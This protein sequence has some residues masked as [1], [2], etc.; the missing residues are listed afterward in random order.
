VTRTILST[1][2]VLFITA[3]SAQI[4]QGG[5]PIGLSR[6]LPA[7]AGVRLPAVDLAALATEDQVNDLDKSIP[8]R[9]GKN[10][11][12]DLDLNNSGTWTTLEDG[13]RLWRLGIVCPGALSVNFEFHDFRPSAGGKVFVTDGWGQHIGAF[14]TANDHGEHVL[15]VQAM[16]GSSITIEYQ[17][18]PTGPVGHLRIGQVTHG[19]RDVFS[20][21]RALGSS[22]S[23]NNNVVC[24]VGDAWRDEIRSVAMIT[25]NGSGICTGTLINNCNSDGTPYFLTANHCLGSNVSTWVFR[26][27][28][29]SPSCTQNQ[30]G[31]TNQ[32]I[33]GSSLL[34]SNAGSD[35]G[36]LLLNSTP[37]AAYNVYYAGW[38]RSGATPTGQTAIHHPSGDV[39]KISFDTDDAG[40]ATYG[41]AACWRI[42]T[43]E[44]GTT[45][46][47]SSGS[48]LWDQNHRLIGQLY[49]GQ[50]TC[51][52]NVNDY[53]GR[54]DVSYPFIQ[55][56]LGS[57]GNTVDGF[58]PNAP[59][60]A[61]DAQLNSIS[62]VSGDPC[63]ASRS[64][65]ITI[66][67]GGTTTLSSFT[68]SWS[69]AGG[70]SGNI[71]WSGSLS[72]GATTVLS[73]GS[74]TLVDGANTFTASVTAPNGGV[75]QNTANDQAQRTSSF[76]TIAVTLDL[77]LDR[78]GEETSWEIRSGASVVASGGPFTREG[79]SGEY[80]Q[81]PIQICLASGCYDLV[82]LDTYGD[83]MCCQYG[84][85][86][87]DLSDDQANVLATGG[88]FTNT[89]THPFCVT[90]TAQVELGAKVF[91]EGPFDSGS[92][93]MGDALRSDGL[94]PTTE[95]YSA[96]GYT[97]V[98]GGGESVQSN[99]LSAT[100]SNAIVDW[101]LVELRG[102]GPSYS[103]AA[104]RCALLQRDGDV[105]DV[106][107]TSPVVFDIGPGNYHVAVRHRNHLGAMTAA[108]VALSGTSV[109]VDFRSTTTSLYGTEAMRTI[110]SARVLWA[111]NC[112]NDGFLRYT[113]SMNDRDRILTR[114]GGS[115]PTNTVAGYFLEDVNMDGQA[116]YTGGSNDRDPI[117]FNIGGSVP[118][119]SRTEQ[120]P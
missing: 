50:A 94:V 107:G 63:V 34:A 96:L 21:G 120:L 78:Y 111:G 97:Q 115:V 28:W 90:A 1:A 84:N 58:D 53:Y 92:Q 10:H 22:G 43:W 71:P 39:K 83:G 112:L 48:G 86:S 45:E 104:T 13:S 25:V 62:G 68:V 64:P 69:L 105:V 47:G 102:A 95:P 17:V 79:S 54:F 72:S 93:L 11:S 49:G 118:T 74:I 16:K 66:R 91:L 44:D 3:V 113:G 100:G 31:P 88:T 106:D 110:G 60:V 4:S 70:A 98:G 15:G 12:V 80:P 55:S 40:Q 87:F 33:S 29:D 85:G 41:S 36:L 109:T 82:V 35:M 114:I 61:L 57:C 23:C 77:T 32:T 59:S 76:G 67:N 101:V 42:F 2:A 99:V 75:D 18:P 56:W 46:P 81:A 30:N 117:L 6:S 52:N 73:I 14:T 5:S 9:F 24:A 116:K 65:Q 20:Y 38:D 7:P 37:P 119:N 26:F 108:P 19:Y 27:N 103:L 89:S 51:S 8:W